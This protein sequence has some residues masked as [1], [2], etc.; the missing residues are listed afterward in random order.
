MSRKKS[1]TS[2]AAA[3]HRSNHN[4]LSH[5]IMPPVR[6]A[7][8]LSYSAGS[9]FRSPAR[10][11]QPSS[12]LTLPQPHPD[13]PIHVPATCINHRGWDVAKTR[14]Q[15][16]V[17]FAKS[18]FFNAFIKMYSC[19]PVSAQKTIKKPRELYAPG[20]SVFMKMSIYFRRYAYSI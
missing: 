5:I 10:R 8:F 15:R 1:V 17:W 14:L 7:M 4:N 13:N 12:I 16:K 2:S 11:H 6:L 18:H 19:V 3:L 20:A 9:F